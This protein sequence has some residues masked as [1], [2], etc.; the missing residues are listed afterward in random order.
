[1]P[2]AGNSGYEV[3]NNVAKMSEAEISKGTQEDSGS[4]AGMLTKSENDIIHPCKTD[5]MCWKAHS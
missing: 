3:E 4:S 1:M 5:V 2:K